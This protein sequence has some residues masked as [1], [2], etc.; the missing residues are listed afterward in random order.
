VAVPTLTSGSPRLTAV[1]RDAGWWLLVLAA[2]LA[3]ARLTLV[4]PQWGCTLALVVLTLGVYARSRRAGLILIWLTW[5]LAPGIRR[6]FGLVSGGGNADPLSLAPFLLTAT[7]ALLELHAARLSRGAGRWLLVALAA[8]AIGLPAGLSSPQAA[9]FAALAYGTG[10]LSFAIG[11]RE[12]LR[13]PPELERILLIAAPLLALYGLVQYV[14]LPSWDQA[15]LSTVD[16]VTA[17]APESG[18]VR[19]FA[20]L[21]SPGTFAMVLALAALCYLTVRRMTLTALAGLTCVLVGLG[22][23]YVRG[24]W[25]ALVLAAVAMTLASRGRTGPRLALIAV[26]AVGSL[27]VAAAQGSTGSAI[28][29]RFNTFGTLGQ[30]ESTQTRLSTPLSVVPQAAGRPLGAGLGSA[31]EPSRLSSAGGFRYTDN[32]YLS[33]LYQVGPLGFLLVAG[34]IGA[35]MRRAWRGVKRSPRGADLLVFG[36]L[37]FILVAAWSGDLLYGVTGIAFWYL[38]GVA[39][40]RDDARVTQRARRSTA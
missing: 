25:G 24:A 22:L 18:R 9:L 6:V 5:L 29:A 16:F 27:A 26:L 37:F 13:R 4:E 2:A 10:I 30:D 19:V 23:T 3:T 20:S 40:R 36:L 32:A 21:N 11:Y 28:V 38:L 7:V 15:W 33:L 39:W 34:A 12:P 14:A 8:Y 31:G 35:G 1:V 17:G